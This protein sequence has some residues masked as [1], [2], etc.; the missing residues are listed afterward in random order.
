MPTSLSLEQRK[1]L[2]RYYLE[3]VWNAQECPNYTPQDMHSSYADAV[4]FFATPPCVY[5]GAERLLIPLIQ[6]CQVVR[7]TF[8]DIRFTIIDIVGEEEKVVVRW[9]LQGTDLG[10]YK[11]HLPTG[12]PMCVTGI[13][14]FLLEQHTIVEERIE[15][16]LA[17][18]LNQLGFV[19][20]PQPP[21]IT[22]RRTGNMFSL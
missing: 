16:D 1:A 8:P 10:G 9:M 20:I 19:S 6:V 14:M 5:F 2:V 3:T 11:E 15:A 18:M 7:K 17:G 22:M 12:R 21:R 4:N 13:S